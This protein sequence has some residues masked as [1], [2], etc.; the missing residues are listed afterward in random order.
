MYF[1][2]KFEI[3]ANNN[4]KPIKNFKLFFNI[5]INHINI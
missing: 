5:L 4:Y 3:F 1:F 2:I